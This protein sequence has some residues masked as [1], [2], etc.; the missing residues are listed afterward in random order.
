M[1]TKIKAQTKITALIA[2]VIIVFSAL[3]TTQALN[4]Q[5]TTTSEYTNNVHNYVTPQGDFTYIEKPIFPVLIN[6][7]QIPV[8]G[9]WTIICPLQANH[10]YHIYCYGSWIN[11]SSTAKT[12]YDFYVFDPQGN[13]ESTHT[14]SA[15]LPPHLGTTTE[16][17]LFTPTQSGNY[18]F[19]ILNNPVDSKSAQQATFMIIENL[20][21]DQ[22]YTTYV[23]GTNN[24]TLNLHT[25]WAYEFVTNASYVELYI[26]VPQTL[27]MYEARLYLMNNASST[28]NDTTLNSFPLPWEP[29]L[30]GN[31]SSSVGGY[32][33]E[34]NGYRGVAFASCEHNGQ[35][36][37]LNYTSNYNGT[38]LFHLMLIG[39]YG[40]GNIEFMLKS[41]FA[42]LTLT[43]LITPRRVYP[44]NATE[45]SY[46]SN[47]TLQTAQFSYTTDNW[48]SATT[49]DMAISNQTCNATIPGQIAGSLVEYTVNATDVQKNC[50]EASGNYTVKEPLTLNITS[51]K[52]EV[53]LGEN[54]TINGYLTPNHNETAVQIRFS[55]SNSTQ[56][57]NSTVSSDNYFVASFKPSTSGTWVV[58]ATSPET[59]TSYR[60][61]SQQLMITVT[62][63]P[64]YVKYS[65]LILMGDVADLVASAAVYF[66]KFREKG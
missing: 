53:R 38:N 51:N 56:L 28:T 63:P 57:I 66:L 32:N 52:E 48:T 33:F 65:L 1:P 24:G 11:T 44:N 47:N 64:I 50:M 3:F 36:M 4:I 5:L 9:N 12:D 45:I 34:S 42:N 30:Y 49:A 29:G 16:D 13:L 6:S 41:Q 15:G 62:E 25:N 21:C 10:N 31:L 8:G 61:D 23:E 26:T 55:N 14:E 19:V 27:D 22:W 40:S 54:I 18:S 37:F 35:S 2:I 59:Q 58:T 39:E 46:S 7:S 20:E 17:P 43:P 60:C